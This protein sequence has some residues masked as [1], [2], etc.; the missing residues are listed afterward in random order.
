MARTASNPDSLGET[1]QGDGVSTTLAVAQDRYGSPDA[2]TLTRA[3]KPTPGPGDV[4][5]SV[6]AASVNARDWHVMRGEPRLARLLDPTTFGLRRPRVA[7]RGTDVAGVIEAVGTGVTR[8]QPGDPVFGEGVGTF[9]Q[10]AVVPSDQIAAIPDGVS[11]EQAAA[12]PLA[13]TTALL[14]LTAADPAPGSSVLINGASGG[15][16]TFAIQLAKTKQLQVTAVVSSRN[17]EL[18]AQLGADQ[19]IDYTAEDFT[20]GP[21]QYDVVI[22]L[23]GNHSLRELRRVVQD[24]GALVLSGGGLSGEGRVLGP[25]KLL[26]WAQLYGRFSSHRILTPQAT[27]DAGLLEHLVELV[28]TARITSVIDRRFPLDQTGD[29]IRYLETTHARAKVLI[30]T[31]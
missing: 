4:L 29:A 30:T 6:K 3:P 10:H 31:E 8:W 19:V 21:K 7:V 18:A 15:V 22:D 1:T 2:L 23:V 25:L 27:P 16:G 26:I 14:C 13:A 20:R 28:R 11:F 24:G 17:V 12:L 5:V 9:A